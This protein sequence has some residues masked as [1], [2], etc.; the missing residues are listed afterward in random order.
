M[1]SKTIN[2]SK[3]KMLRVVETVNKPA[4][5]DGNLDLYF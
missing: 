3:I 1:I 2:N 5:A 4:S